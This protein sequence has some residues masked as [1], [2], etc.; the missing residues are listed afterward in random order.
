MNRYQISKQD[1]I[2][3][4]EF[5]QNLETG[6]Y[7]HSPG[8]QRVLNVMRGGPKEGKYVLIVDEPFRSWHL[9]K[10]PARRGEPV[11]RLRD[12]HFTD[13]KVAEWTVFKLRWQEQTGEALAV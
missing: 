6:N 4:L 1:K 9:G 12:Y 13:L 7:Y 11:T 3:A 2:Y 5:K 8:L 10:M